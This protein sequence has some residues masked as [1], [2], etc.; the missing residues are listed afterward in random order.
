L[1]LALTPAASVGTLGAVRVQRAIARLFV[2][3]DR[4]AQATSDFLLTTIARNRAQQAPIAINAAIGLAIIIA[5]LSRGAST[6]TR[7]AATRPA[8]VIRPQRFCTA[9]NSGTPEDIREQVRQLKKDG[10][11]L[12]VSLSNSGESLTA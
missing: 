9:H 2:G 1:Q 5:G 11:D 4:V 7:T 12:L 6:S 8:A 3:R 10:A